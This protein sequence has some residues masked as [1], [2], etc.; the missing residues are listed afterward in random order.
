MV[1]VLSAFDFPSFI[2]LRFE[3]FLLWPIAFLA[4]RQASVSKLRQFA[5][6]KLQKLG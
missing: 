2:A 5:W 6:Q 4:T 3:W 1:I